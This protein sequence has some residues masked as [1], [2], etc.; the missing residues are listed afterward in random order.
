MILK[1]GEGSTTLK[2]QM[3]GIEI[4]EGWFYT[5]LIRGYTTPPM[6]NMNVLSVEVMIN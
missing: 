1:D 2:L 6:G 3:P 5:I 4:Q